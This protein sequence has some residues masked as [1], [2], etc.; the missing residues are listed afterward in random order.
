MGEEEE[1]T[2]QVKVKDMDK[3]TETLV[4]AGEIVAFLK[5]R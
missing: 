3:R 1:A 5:N 2:G 4:P